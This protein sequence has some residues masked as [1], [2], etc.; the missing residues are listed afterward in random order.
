[1]NIHEKVKG[2]IGDHYTVVNDLEGRN[3]ICAGP[4][5]GASNT[6]DKRSKICNFGGCTT[7][8]KSTVT[9]DDDDDDDDDDEIRNQSMKTKDDDIRKHARSVLEH[10]ASHERNQSM[11]TKDDDIGKHARSV[12][13]HVALH[14][15]QS[16]T[17]N[18]SRDDEG[19][20]VFGYGL[21]NSPIDSP[22]VV[23]E[24]RV[25]P[26]RPPLLPPTLD[27]RTLTANNI[28]IA[29]PLPLCLFCDDDNNTMRHLSTLT[30]SSSSGG[31][32]NGRL[33]LPCP[34]WVTTGACPFGRQCGSSE[35]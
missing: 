1:M 26:L 11:K 17:N 28:D 2:S 7:I 8:V 33:A 15:R 20:V 27:N 25:M 6:F 13:E 32:N 21:T 12:L 35:C 34:T 9:D 23:S 24:R 29:I 14:E 31:G 19:D 22:Q 16:I 4:C 3:E 30:S 5:T 10:V 18:E